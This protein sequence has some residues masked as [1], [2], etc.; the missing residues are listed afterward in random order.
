MFAGL[1]AKL[2]ILAMRCNLPGRLRPP[3][4]IVERYDTQTSSR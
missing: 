3:N 4:A 1:F 2:S